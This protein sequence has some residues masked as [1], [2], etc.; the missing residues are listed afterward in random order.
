MLINHTSI[1]NYQYSANIFNRLL[2]ILFDISFKSIFFLYIKFHLNSQADW[3]FLEP[4]YYRI[5]TFK[6]FTR[7]VSRDLYRVQNRIKRECKRFGRRA[8]GF[9]NNSRDSR[10]LSDDGEG[11]KELLEE[12]LYQR[13]VRHVESSEQKPCKIEGYNVRR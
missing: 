4:Y 1:K 10:R 7:F 12:F 13:I 3:I 9:L 6:S 11:R 5:F 2:M 8:V